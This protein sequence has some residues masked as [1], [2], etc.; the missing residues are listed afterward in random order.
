MVK[1]E[2]ISTLFQQLES[3]VDTL[4]GDVEIEEAVALYEKGNKLLKK[5]EKRLESARDKITV[6]SADGVTEIKSER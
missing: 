6:L 2:R 5:I 1:K 3:L 4:D